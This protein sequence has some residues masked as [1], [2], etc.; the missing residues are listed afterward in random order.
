MNSTA[1]IRKG[2]VRRLAAPGIIVAPGVYD[3]ISAVL[4]ER[5]GFEAVFFS[6]S[7]MATAH[8][9][10]PDIGLLSVTEVAGT[11][12][13]AAERLTIPIVV[14]VDQAY[15]G[16]PQAARTLQTFER[17]G[18]SAVQ[19]EDQVLVKPGKA[20][21]SRPLLPLDEM[22]DKLK[23]MLDTRHSSDMLIS[24]RTDAKDPAEAVDRCL[25]FRD[26]GADIVFPEGTTDVDALQALRNALD[27]DARMIYNNHYPDAPIQ[28]A[29]G[30]E[31]LG[32]DLVLFPVQAVRSAMAAMQETFA[33]ISSDPSLDGAG[34][35]A[36]SAADV[37]VIIDAPTILSKF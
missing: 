22:L 10:M 21:T 6:G 14:D 8:L 27:Q 24:A 28:S 31:A 11:V 19:V 12:Q 18:A 26:A 7:A 16:A 36:L 17:A 29:Q 1:E 30:A 4:A 32:I 2:F 9:A 13:R 25:A 3:A 20:L 37:D 5:A 23:A 34:R 33:N 15:G 35:A